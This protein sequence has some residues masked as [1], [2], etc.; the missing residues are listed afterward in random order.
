MLLLMGKKGEEN[1]KQ[2]E[3]PIALKFLQ[4]EAFICAKEKPI[5]PK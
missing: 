1:F 3:V 4:V 2:F 5:I